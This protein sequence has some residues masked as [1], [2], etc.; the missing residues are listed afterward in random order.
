[1]GHVLLLA[2]PIRHFPLVDALTRLLTRRGARVSVLATD[3]V[4]RRFLQAHG[5]EARELSPA[6]RSASANPPITEFAAR[7]ALLLGRA[8]D[9]R[10]KRRCGALLA[11]QASPLVRL[12]ESESPDVALFVDDRSGF[13]RLMHATAKTFGCATAQ[14][15]F[16][17][18]PGTLQR[19]VDGIDGDRSPFVL[20]PAEPPVDRAFLD[21]ALAAALALGV[22]APDASRRVLL[23]PDVADTL[24][25]WTS[26]WRDGGLA[27][28]RARLRAWRDAV[29][30]K[31]RP[32]TV[33]SSLLP[34][35]PYLT[36]LL[37]TDEDPRMRLDAE[38]A[39]SQA[40]LIAATRRATAALGLELPVVAVMPHASASTSA[41]DFASFG[42]VTCVPAS[43]G[44]SAVVTA[45]A[46]VTINHPQAFV[47]ALA[48]TPTVCLGR[49]WF[50]QAPLVRAGTPDRLEDLLHEALQTRPDVDAHRIAAH[51]LREDHLWCDPTHP[52]SNGLAGIA[53]WI[54]ALLARTAPT[55]PPARYEPG[56][57]WPGRGGDHQ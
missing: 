32:S 26:A 16:G 23:A 25:A 52:D 51:V 4:A 31:A 39:M 45:A 14:L 8:D 3:R 57:A 15:G 17:L 22:P 19:D 21:S 40:A 2:P 7:D 35:A 47:S 18:I 37:Q 36:V 30:E 6:R 50:A 43:M 5:I 11:A 48:G 46:T 13:A 56:P 10:T 44:A 55:P 54:E 1:M 9:A 33:D 34:R 53:A 49:A 38:F 27:A 24:S 28:T 42:S 12:F 41:C 29:L 20:G